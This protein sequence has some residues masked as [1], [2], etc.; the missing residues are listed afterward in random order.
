[1]SR[2][3]DPVDIFRQFRYVREAQQN[4]QNHGLRINA[5]QLWA[6]GKDGDSYCCE[7]WWMVHDICYQGDFPVPREQS[8]AEALAFCMGQGWI[9]AEPEPN[10]TFFYVDANGHAHHIGVVT[11]GYP[12]LTGIAGNTSEDGASSNGDGFHEHALTVPRAHVVFARVPQ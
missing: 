8:C 3:Y 5:I 11:E 7:A 12:N 4:G 6:G 2:I 9:V 1:M 10:D